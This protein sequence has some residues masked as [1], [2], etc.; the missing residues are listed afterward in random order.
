MFIRETSCFE[1]QFLYEIHHDVKLKETAHQEIIRACID[2]VADEY[3]LTDEHKDTLTVYLEK[4][5]PQS[6][7]NFLEIPKTRRLIIKKV[8]ASELTTKTLNDIDFNSLHN[9]IANLPP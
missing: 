9:K 4:Q 8:L 3:I 2:T 6:I 7:I 1:D 5:S